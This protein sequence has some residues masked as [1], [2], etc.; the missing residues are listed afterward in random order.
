MTPSEGGSEVRRSRV[1]D[2]WLAFCVVI[3]AAWIVLLLWFTARGV[4]WTAGDVVVPV[5]QIA[6]LVFA[7]TMEVRRR[8]GG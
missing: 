5:V 3:L 6:A 4:N 1:R 7:I 2:L 8:R